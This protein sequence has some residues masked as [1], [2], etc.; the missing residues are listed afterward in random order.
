MTPKNRT[1][2]SLA[3]IT[4]A[5][6][7]RL[8]EM[9]DADARRLYERYPLWRGRRVGSALAQGA[10]SHFVDGITGVKDFDVWSFFARIPGTRFP[11]GGRRKVHRDFGISSHGRQLFS[12]DVRA[13]PT[14]AAKV[15]TWE[16]FSGR[17][18]DLMM[19]DLACASAADPR[20]AITDW[21][22]D[23]AQTRTRPSLPSSWWLAQKAVVLLFPR[24]RL[25]E[26]VWPGRQLC[27][28]P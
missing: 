19:R 21:L 24:E 26:V 7:E 17:R 2:R 13:D 16:G 14:L 18:V 1:P 12:D 9:A 27:P 28:A 3:A 4:R 11:F 25:G 23:G 10:A 20:R 15:H 5:D 6:L 22:R 8:A